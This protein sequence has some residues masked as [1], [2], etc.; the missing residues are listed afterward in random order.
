[1]ANSIVN[2]IHSVA[3]SRTAKNIYLVFLG[4]GFNSLLGFITIILISR[5]LGPEKFGLFSLVLAVFMGAAKLGDLGLNF[6]AARY[7]ARNK[8]K[9]EKRAKYVGITLRYKLLLTLLVTLLG[10][11]V[12]PYLAFSVFKQESLLIPLQL[13]FLFLP[14]LVLYDFYLALTQAYERFFK[15]ILVSTASSA[16]KLF[17]IY[18]LFIKGYFSVFNSFSIYALG[19]LLGFILAFI[20]LPKGYLRTDIKNLNKEGR[21]IVNFSKWMGISVLIASV[22]ERLDIYMIS[23]MLGS[24]DTGIY[25]A[26]SRFSVLLALISGAVGIVLMPKASAIVKKADLRK[27]LRK[28][29]ILVGAL[30]VF[31]IAIYV[32]APILFKYTF[33]GQYEASVGIFRIL[34][35]AM[36][37]LAARGP[38]SASFFSLNKPQYF[39]YS[40]MISIVLIFALNLAFIPSYGAIGA[41]YS[42]LITRVLLALYT[43]WYL[44]KSLK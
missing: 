33:G 34:S 19:P 8:G 26:A 36:I 5:N 15:S 32:S 27:Y 35:F 10:Y 31:F 21:E 23:N 13:S 41:S 4:N 6:A 16:F 39:A 38:L 44:K 1:L 17:A 29:P 18:Y 14:G 11:L 2:K 40:S 9:E 22:S 43:L 12:S 42:H 24:F 3:S 20:L 28:V 25:S 30:F 7:V 37:I